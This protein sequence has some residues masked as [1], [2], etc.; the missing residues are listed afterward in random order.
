MGASNNVRYPINSDPSA[1]GFFAGDV[2]AP[3]DA[4]RTML[5]NDLYFG[6]FHEGGGVQFCFADGSVLML[7][8]AIDFQVFQDLATR[9]GEEIIRFGGDGIPAVIQSR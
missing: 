4:P 8:D 1:Y 6:S 9:T 2:N 3:T 7:S 5:L